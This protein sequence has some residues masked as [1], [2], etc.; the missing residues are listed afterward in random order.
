MIIPSLVL[1]TLAGCGQPD[2]PMA[3]LDQRYTDIMVD[4]G[5]A[6]RDTARNVRNKEARRRKARA[7]KARVAF[8][9]DKGVQQTIES[10]REQTEDPLTAIKAES[11]WRHLVVYRP[12]TEDEKAEETRLLGHLEEER[13]AEAT[14]SSPDGSVTVELDSGWRDV[15]RP[16]DDLSPELRTDLAGTFVAHQMRLVGSDLQDLI[17]LRNEVARRE[18]FDNYWELALAGHGLKPADVD[19]IIADMTEVVRP[20]NAAVLARIEDTAK[21]ERIPFSWENVPT[22]RRLAGLEAARDDADAYFDTDRA[23]ERVMTALQ[24]M[25]ISTDGWQ[26]YSGPTRYVRP[27]VYGF[28]IR[29]PDHVAIVMSQDVRWSVWQYEA[30]AHE[31]GHAMWWKAINPDVAASPAMWEPTSPWFEGF[32]QFFERL[33]YEPSFSVRYVP[34]LPAEEREALRRWR[35]DNMARWITDSIIDTLVERRLYE[36]PNSLEA[37]TRFAAETRHALTGE[38]MPPATADGLTYTG[39]LNSSLL[40]NYPSYAQNYLFAYMTEAWLYEAV[41]AQVGDPIANEKVG[42]LLQQKLV[43]ADPGMDF[44]ERLAALAPGD[45]TAPLKKYLQTPEPMEVEP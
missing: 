4:L 42:P 25:G 17:R 41:V 26:V 23:E 5:V 18:G 22:L 29:P 24:D 2:D 16:A 33:V 6:D 15:S 1:L 19:A 28:P 31:G 11:Y 38:P 10:A 45:R 20:I 27:G 8:F 34:E 9:H 3:A 35:A 13:S 43:R 40:W 37:V 44:P 7:E 14:W 32:A 21:T 12:W 30:L 36:D 39:S